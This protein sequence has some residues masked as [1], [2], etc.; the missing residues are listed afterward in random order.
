VFARDTD[1]NF[2]RYVYHYTRWERLLDISHTGL[3]LGSLAQM[4]DPRESKY[5]YLGHITYDDQPP[6]DVPAFRDAVEDYKR[7]IKIASF[8]RD[9]PGE[10]AEEVRFRS[11]YAR[12][13]MW[14]QYAA[15]HTGVCIVMDREGLRNAMQAQLHKRD[16]SWLASGPVEYIAKTADD[17]SNQVVEFFPERGGDVA[18]TVRNYFFE[19]RNRIFFAKHS[20][21]R[22]EAEYRWVYY[23]T[24]NSSN[25]QL[26]L[27]GTYIQIKGQVAALVLGADYSDAH[28]PVAQSFATALGLNGDVARCVWDRSSLRMDV[29][30]NPGG[31]WV[32]VPYRGVVSLNMRVG[33]RRKVGWNTQGVKG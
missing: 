31:V 19:H 8:S 27:E 1:F 20:D 33:I 17:P 13:R 25:S 22:D 4:N 14:A 28:L 5:W 23:D 11:G 10:T 7:H 16:D 32:P 29:F 2:D 9:M 24:V 15:N 21:W 3:R 18:T 12:P 30:A 26:N 6:V